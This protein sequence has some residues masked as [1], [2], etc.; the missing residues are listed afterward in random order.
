LNSPN[1]VMSI[2]DESPF[3]PLAR[4]LSPAVRN[5]PLPVSMD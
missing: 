5:H 1:F 3:T 4:G 2:S